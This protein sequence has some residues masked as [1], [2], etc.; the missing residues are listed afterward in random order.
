M[1]S[2]FA[3]IYC[4][5]FIKRIVR[6]GNL[7]TIILSGAVTLILNAGFI[8]PFADMYLKGDH[9]VKHL[10]R[11]IGG[12]GVHPLQLL[13]FKGDYTDIS[14]SIEEGLGLFEEMP[15]TLGP[16][17]V[18]IFLLAA[19]GLIRSCMGRENEDRHME[20]TVFAPVLMGLS[21]LAL[22]MTT[23]FFPYDAIAKHLSPV[24]AIIGGVQFP[25]RYLV[26]ATLLL[27]TLTIYV[28]RVWDKRPVRI[29]LW[30]V[31]AASALVFM[32]MQCT[33]DNKHVDAM[34]A[35]GVKFSLMD[36][37]IMYL[38]DDMD[39]ET[40]KDRGLRTSEEAVTSQDMGFDGRSYTVIA[41]DPTEAEGWVELP[42]IYYE[43][44]HSYTV[45]GNG[46][47]KARDEYKITE[48]DDHRIRLILP[49]GCRD[50][51]EIRY[52]EPWYYRASEL[53]GMLTFIGLAVWLIRGR[54]G[55]AYK[56]TVTVADTTAATEETADE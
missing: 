11:E 45:D 52:A 26:I 56:D 15:F 39:P 48:G 10:T 30:I 35:E 19:A 43:G 1:V 12:Q 27:S 7:L 5:I 36:S 31:T 28:C 29:I 53:A 44:Y 51:V 8:V 34:N 50:M 17:L 38:P 33:A 54:A 47:V 46:D 18:L 42:L 16:V 37:D 6:A 25:W 3:L 22:F 24:A 41:D 40:L 2:V 49:A 14:H 13:S 20:R 32:G 9:V 4:L 23:F 55:A 21:V